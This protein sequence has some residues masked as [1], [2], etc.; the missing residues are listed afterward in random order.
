MAD[1]TK[2]LSA[3][4]RLMI[5]LEQAKRALAEVDDHL[6]LYRDKDALVAIKFAQ[7][8][9]AGAAIEL[10]TLIQKPMAPH[11][12]RSTPSGRTAGRPGR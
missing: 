6:H 11:S 5:R 10:A 8:L 12:P 1:S 2:S 4:Q 3:S 9:L 7:S